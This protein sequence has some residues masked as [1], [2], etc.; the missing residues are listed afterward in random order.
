MGFNRGGGGA[1]MADKHYDELYRMV[2]QLSSDMGRR[3]QGITI[4]HGAD[5]KCG[6]PCGRMPHRPHAYTR[7]CWA[8]KPH[9]WR[10]AAGVL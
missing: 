8:R 10:H 2:Q 6:P 4:V 3:Q 9:A 1:T 7:I 5:S